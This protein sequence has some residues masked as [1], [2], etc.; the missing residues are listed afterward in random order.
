MTLDAAAAIGDADQ[1]ET[2]RGQAECHLGVRFTWDVTG[3]H[4]HPRY[5]YACVQDIERAVA[6]AVRAAENA[7]LKAIT[8]TGVDVSPSSGRFHSWEP[9]MI[10]Y[11]EDRSSGWLSGACS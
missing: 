8:L 7:P 3:G 4:H 2:M 10:E 1:Q 5:T 9:L 6:A 11:S